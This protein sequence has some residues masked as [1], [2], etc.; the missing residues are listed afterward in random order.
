MHT[1][2]DQLVPVAQENFYADTVVAAGASDM[3]RQAFVW[4]RLHCNFTPAE[5]VAGVLAVQHRV[6]TGHWDSVAR[7]NALEASA[8]SLLGLGG[9]AFIPY[10]PAVLS[11]FNGRFNA[12]VDGISTG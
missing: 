3:L 10:E 2:A 1:I 12:T 4:R 8:N 7:P 5:L 11:G 9:A 6:A